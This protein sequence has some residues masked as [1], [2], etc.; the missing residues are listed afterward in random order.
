MFISKGSIAVRL[1]Y[2]ILFGVIAAVPQLRAADNEDFD[3]YTVRVDA[4]WFNAR[5]SGVF[6]GTRGNGLFDLQ[7]DIHFNTYTTFSGGVDWKFTR[8]NHLFFGV[9]PFDRTKHFVVNRP[10]MFQGHT[11]TIGLAAAAELKT[12]GYAFGYQYDIIRRKRGH[13]GIRAQI[14]LFDVDGTLSSSAQITNGT[15]HV[16]QRA[17]GS[18]RA[19][20]PVAGP[21]VRFY[22][23]SDSDRLYV[24]GQLLGMY[25]FGYGDF[26]S[27]IETLGLAVNRHFAIRGGYQLAQRFNINNRSNRI[28]LNLTQKGP[29]AGL[30]FSF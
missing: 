15:F 6:R 5:P 4:F 29:V 14:D 12:N 11:Y 2:L 28:G 23:L 18:L 16:S 20:L 21:N 22:L 7:K 19:P 9:T 17:Q 10:I 13:I 1:L 24:T 3:A 8:K 27:T 26:L 25:F 30:E